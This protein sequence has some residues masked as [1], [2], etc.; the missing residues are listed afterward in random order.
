MALDPPREV[1]M[2]QY[3]PG[4]F[5][6]LARAVMRSPRHS[7]FG[8]VLVCLLAAGLSSLLEIDPN[9]LGL[10]PESDPTT[11][12]IQK[13]ND[14]E[15]GSNLVTIAFRGEDPEALDRFMTELADDISQLP[16]VDYVLYELDEDL[17]WRLSLLQLSPQELGELKSR[18]QGAIAL[19][20][21]AANPMIAGRLLALGPLTEKLASGGSASLT[22]ADEPGVARMVVR[23]TGSA[24]DPPFAGPFMN[25]VYDV[26]DAQDPA[27]RGLE[28]AWLGGAYH[29]AVE[30]VE[31]ITHDLSRTALLSLLLVVIVVGLGFRDFRAVLLIFVPLLI[32]NLLTWGLA[33]ATVGELN[34][35]TSFFAAI[36]IGLGVDFSIHLY[37]R[38]REERLTSPTLEEAV[39]RAWD[40]TGPPCT[41]AALTSAGGFAALWIAG[42][43]G[44]QQLGT[45][46][47]GG[48]LLCLLAVLVT[49]PLLILWREGH[50][51]TVPLRE[52]RIPRRTT[53][54][55]YRLAPIGL[56]VIVALT[57]TAATWLPD[58]GFEYDLSELRRDG[59]AY[60]DLDE[61]EKKLVEDS[62]AP[63]IISYP[64]AASL[65]ADHT[66]LNAAI[67]ADALT[68]IKSAISIYSI[69]P[70]DQAQRVSLLQDLAVLSRDPNMQ[71]LPPPI[72][73]NLSRIA[74]SEPVE[75]SADD[76]PH[77][78]RHMLG[79]SDG[80]HR[81]VLM[82]KGNMWN[83]QGDQALFDEVH[84]LIPDQPAA[85]EY[86]ALA[87]LYKLVETDAPRI[88]GLATLLIFAW[89]LIDLRS[90][91]RALGA[92][93]AV[94][95]GMIWA[96]ACMVLFDLKLSL[97]NFVG[98]PILM[99]IGIDVV[100][101]LLHRMEE[102]GPGRIRYALMTTGW[103][104]F[105]STTT[106]I[107]SFSALQIASN[108]G[109]RSLGMVIMVG[110]AV[111][112][113]AAFVSV[114]LGWMMTWKVK[115]ELPETLPEEP[116]TP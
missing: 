72:R 5:G 80:H 7:L 20:A 29:H 27:S 71:Y 85:G 12:A 51:K 116:S 111:V 86:L 100:I 13:I 49:L 69:L 35:F 106:T 114:S 38:Y 104:A 99:G 70:I 1:L 50:N 17:A 23:P 90:L 89:T 113:I 45:L 73:E 26:I 44:F 46:L 66:R 42:F 9:I 16:D 109:V 31:G 88:A 60:S 34:T 110:L 39:M 11:Q 98:I 107:L 101:H 84:S 83:L 64:D 76:L 92:V 21:G 62:F 112:T 67:D 57:A 37:S 32:G 79:A 87:V 15:G 65:Q 59:R 19:G 52:V 36:L 78:V 94:A 91:G 55:R 22:A 75:L 18:L 54:P 43:K 48:V 53:P 25:S 93:A 6:R 41:T 77:G 82:P 58:I 4:L 3:T 74:A 24:Y 30:E 14:E 47:T 103:A 102:E 2:E 63:V 97:V 108:Q 8:V 68:T 115:G 105:L 81:M 95:V 56:V 28:L 33:G 40:A 96:G 10:L 61:A